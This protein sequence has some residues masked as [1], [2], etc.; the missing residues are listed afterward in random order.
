MSL[1]NSQVA[2]FVDS[3]NFCH[4][5]RIP[6]LKFIDFTIVFKGYLENEETS[7][8]ISSLNSARSNMLHN[9]SID[10]NIELKLLTLETYLPI[11]LKLLDSLLAQ[12]PVEINRT[13]MFEWKGSL[14]VADTFNLYPE[15]IYEIIMVLHTKSIL[16]Y[17]IGY[18]YA[19]QVLTISNAGQQFLAAANTSDYL[20]NSI[21]PKWV[22]N[23]SLQMTRP[24]G[25]LARYP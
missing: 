24:P 15:I 11:I 2:S 22:S 10:C 4:E 8:F 6:S 23:I 17:I 7:Q 18:E 16:H 25:L 9:L 19:K 14:S 20:S 21:I 12:S 13:L 1:E 5:F 3:L